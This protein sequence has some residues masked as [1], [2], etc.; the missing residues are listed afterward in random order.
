[1]IAVPRVQAVE[2]HAVTRFGE[3][4]ELVVARPGR[5]NHRMMRASCRLIG[6]WAILI[7]LIL[8]STSRA[9]GSFEADVQ[10][11]CSFGS[12]LPGSAGYNQTAQMLREQLA[13]L[14]GVELREQSFDVMVPVTSHAVLRLENGREV[15]VAPFWPAH[16]RL[17]AT[18]IGG[19]TGKLIY[20]GDCEYPRIKPNSLAGNIAVVEAR[21]KDRWTR[22]FYFGAK[23]ILVLPDSDATNIE[24]S[25]FDI[26]PPANL[27]R[28]YLE[29]AELAKRL[30]NGDELG[31]VKLDVG[32]N[33]KTIRATNFYA[34]LMPNG[35]PKPILVDKTTVPAAAT[36]FVVPFDSSSLVYDRAPGASQ[37][38]NIAAAL[39]MAREM[40]SVL[41]QPDPT[42]TRPVMFVFTGADGISQLG[43]RTM[44]LSVAETPLLWRSEIAEIDTTLT[45]LAAQRDRLVEIGMEPWRLE[46]ARDRDLIKRLVSMIETDLSIQQDRLFRIRVMP[47]NLVTD[48]LRQQQKTY[49]ENQ[50]NLSGVRAALQTD[51]RLLERPARKELAVYYAQQALQRI[52]GAANT[53]GLIEQFGKRKSEL[54][55]R[56]DLALWL[57]ERTGR[58]DKDGKVVEPKESNTANRLLD[59]IIGLDLSDGGTSV[60]PMFHGTYQRVGSKQ[61]ISTYRDVFADLVAALD[62]EPK[63]RSPE[64]AEI[65]KWFG[66]IAGSIDFDPLDTSKTPISFIGQTPIA[67]EMASSWGTAGFSLLTLHDFRLLRDTP[68]DTFDRLRLP[69]IRKQLDAVTTLMSKVLANPKFAYLAEIRRN[70]NAFVG[71]VVGTAPGKPVP[72]L[73]M[74]GFLVSYQW[75][76]N[77]LK[78]PTLQWDAGYIPGVRRT[79]VRETDVEGRFR[80][81]GF[82][83]YPSQLKRAFVQSFYMEKDSGVIKAISDLGRSSSDI[84]PFA[85]VQ[86]PLNP[87]R[88]L[89]F[90]CEEVSLVGLYDPRFLQALGEVQIIDARRNT[91]APRISAT[92]HN[93]IL[94]AFLEPASRNYYLFRY[95]QI[96]NRLIL[97]NMPEDL[98]SAD[99]RSAKLGRGFTIEDAREIGPLA[100]ATARDFGQLDSK[101]LDDY[102]SAGVSSQLIDDMHD[103]ALHQLNDARQ[104][105][106]QDDAVGAVRNGNGAWAAEALV[107][108][109]SKSMANDVIR[110]AIF[111]L[112]LAV[113]FSICIERLLIASP[114]V[115]RQI[116]GVAAIFTVMTGAL[117]AF[118]PAFKISSSPLIII[119]SFAIIFM[120]IVVIGVVYQKFDAEL[121]K[122]RSGRGTSEGANFLR[123][124]VLTNAVMLGIANMRKRK[125]RT[126]LTATTIV[127]ITFAVLVFA[128][129]SSFRSTKSYPTGIS[130]DHPG[131]LLR[132]RGYR[133]MPIDIVSELGV[134]FPKAQIVERWWNTNAGEPNET[135]LIVSD[136]KQQKP[137]GMQALLGLSPGES[138][139]SRVA[140]VIGVEKFARLENGETNIIYLST[141][142]AKQLSVKEG[143]TVRIGGIALEVAGIFDGADF[144]RKVFM[145]SGE[146]LTPLKY[147]RNALD[148]GGKALSDNAAESITM[149]ADTGGAELSS[150]Y[151]HLPASQMAIISAKVSQR[152]NNARLATVALRLED[153]DVFVDRNNRIVAN[154]SALALSEAERTTQRI[155]KAKLVKWAADEVARRFTIVTYAGLEDGVQLISASTPTKITGS[156]VAIPLLIGGLIIF[157]TM[158]GSIAERKR[159]IHIYTSLGLAPLHVGAL[160]VAEALTYGVIGT[161]FGYII[162]Q[163]VG[164][165]MLKLGWLGTMTLDYSGTSAM[166]TIGLI[167]LV[168][169]LSAL[170]PARLASK[171]AAPSIERSWKVPAPKNGQIMATLPFTINRTAAEGVVAYLAEYFEGHKEGSIGKFATDD[172]QAFAWTGEEKES[173]GKP[174]RGVQTTVWLTPFDL[175]V[176]QHLMLLIHPGQ[177]PDIYEVQVL[178]S[179][180]SGDDGSWYRM[181]RSFLTELRKQ[182]LQW[183]SLSPTRMREY[184]EA[185]KMLFKPGGQVT[186]V[187][188]VA[189]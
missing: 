72:D 141:E 172:V 161:V 57:A 158:M 151:Q 125:I 121:K 31:E 156:Q 95:G 154:E 185:S 175:G 19:L 8:G 147:E 187:E 134:V 170:V 133:P 90:E 42:I 63:D 174:S 29:D 34:L 165:A 5:G 22:A 119:L 48:E 176:R 184:V 65:S 177:F 103:D 171:I 1:M 183:R 159:E 40:A 153:Q 94:A 126:T 169:L 39:S 98:K 149:D 110:A 21:S 89:P 28:F 24:F 15:N 62:R 148:A 130:S 129:A 64:Q 36:T 12:R 87:M 52:T 9:D 101:R 109:A 182:F 51:V 142:S 152:L 92:L 23:A 127:L 47:A 146:P 35:G 85:D 173:G 163:G 32:A 41:S 73:P 54:Q 106:Q 56:I 97:I 143:D 26:R 61:F 25:G 27:P 131:L 122:I 128:S 4:G 79:E 144:D 139:L 71:Q 80:F 14:P 120:S 75:T 105:I 150:V 189:V 83:K 118:H 162:G 46:P 91:D 93:R 178:L 37:A 70:R 168:V 100:L 67:S 11:I 113:P 84:T 108:S 38:V 136:A 13:K 20:I 68:N 145:L 74:S 44:L 132:Q 82:S 60:G 117:W 135:N 96:G 45:T 88:S 111:L 186:N 53:P 18:P 123:A 76:S 58:W 86:T 55:A 17:S 77:T 124:S 69:V 166:L 116:A 140:E 102:R 107:Y 49:E 188:E 7:A 137:L 167:L 59:V 160:F 2:P 164:T 181:N 115:Y 3:P 99:D 179:R 16:T 114:N 104:A 78:I 81:E 155:S 43:T 30:R 66:P 138:K 180:L 112:L 33:W 157:N 6:L 50:I 10:T